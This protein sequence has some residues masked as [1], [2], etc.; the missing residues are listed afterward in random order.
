MVLGNLL[1]LNSNHYSFKLKLINIAIT[2]YTNTHT[3][4]I[5]TQQISFYDTKVIYVGPSN[6]LK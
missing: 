2:C 4:V 6:G 5:D 3:G 1:K